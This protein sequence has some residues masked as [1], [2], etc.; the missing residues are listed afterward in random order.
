MRKLITP[1]NVRVA[2]SGHMLTADE[3]GDLRVRAQVNGKISDILM[4]GILS[5]AE[6]EC[7]LLS[8]QK[9]EINGFLVTF[10]DSKEI[11]KKGNSVAA[12]AYR[13]DKLYELCV[14]S[15]TETAN[16]C[17]INETPVKHNCGIIVWNI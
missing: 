4:T 7:N 2:K 16:F 12:I 6:L 13:K 17:R 15:V 5:V 9:F 3:I 1:I 14:E 8:V 11:I 10:E